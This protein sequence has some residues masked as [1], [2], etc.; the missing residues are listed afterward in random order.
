MGTL[1]L[2]W[3]LHHPQMTAIILGPRRPEHLDP[4]VA[5]LGLTLSAEEAVGSGASSPFA[6][7]SSRS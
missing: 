1:A 7:R 2:A 4:A 6:R 3:A 5:A